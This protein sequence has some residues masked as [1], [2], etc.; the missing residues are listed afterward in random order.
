MYDEY[1]ADKAMKYLLA[2]K[3][4]IETAQTIEHE[5]QRPLDFDYA[6][7]YTEIQQKTALIEKR[8]QEGPQDFSDIYYLSFYRSLDKDVYTVLDQNTP[9]RL[10]IANIRPTVFIDKM[11][12][13]VSQRMRLGG[14]RFAKMLEKTGRAFD[15]FLFIQ[16]YVNIWKGEESHEPGEYDIQQQPT[17][18]ALLKLVQK[19]IKMTSMLKQN[20]EAIFVDWLPIKVKDLCVE[21]GY[22]Y[23]GARVF[24]TFSEEGE[25]KRDE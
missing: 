16:A 6:Q 18:E 3:E 4:L 5:I 14:L 24:F 10:V 9:N 23:L 13:N 7:A 1:D 21:G 17:A 8:K 20:E 19:D 25:L 22:G 2:Q 11:E 12:A 15:P